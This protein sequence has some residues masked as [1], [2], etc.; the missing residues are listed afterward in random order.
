MKL[1][2]LSCISSPLHSKYVNTRKYIYLKAIVMMAVIYY[3]I[4]QKKMKNVHVPV[5]VQY[6]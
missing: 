2:Y 5:S 3:Y 4:Q 1:S 6:S